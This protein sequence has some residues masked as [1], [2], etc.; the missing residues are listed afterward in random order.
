MTQARR[1]W[2]SKN[3][4]H[5]KVYERE[6][7][8]NGGKDRRLR[9]TYGITLKQYDMMFDDQNGVCWICGKPPIGQPLSVDHC[10]KT[11][12]VR[13]LL[14]HTCNRG[15]GYYKDN[16]DWLERAAQYLRLRGSGV[17]TNDSTA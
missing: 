6:R 3:V 10:H 4:E 2:A 14:C 7:W 13:G 11:G 12:V 1:E 9:Q 8:Q 16:P 15:L 5:R 17:E